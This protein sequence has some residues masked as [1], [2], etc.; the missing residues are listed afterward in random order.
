M[1]AY[2]TEDEMINLKRPPSFFKKQKR[3]SNQPLSK[4]VKLSDDTKRQQKEERMML[5]QHE[6]AQQATQQELQRE[7]ALLDVS[8]QNELD[9]V[10]QVEQRMTEITALLSQ[11]SSLVSEQQEEVSAIHQTTVSSKENITKGQESL[12]DAKERTKRSKHY[13]AT[14]VWSVAILLLVF[15]YII[16]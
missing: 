2:T 9:S 16:P 10:Y 6:E 8:L 14:F 13:M 1:V 11:F 12:V 5:Y 7:A 3:E 15:N 4:P